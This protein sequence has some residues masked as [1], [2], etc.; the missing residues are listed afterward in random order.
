MQII[1]LTGQDIAMR[2][3][4]DDYTLDT[5]WLPHQNVEFGT[6][7]IRQMLDFLDQDRFAALAAYN[8]GP[9]NVQS[10]LPFPDDFA[11][12]LNRRCR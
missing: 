3:G 5:L 1:P 2:L 8:A 9:G 11:A 4:D 12:P 7:Y 6:S 10:W